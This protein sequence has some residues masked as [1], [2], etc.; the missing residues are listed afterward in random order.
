MLTLEKG[1]SVYSYAL[2]IPPIVRH[3]H[4]TLKRWD[5]CIGVILMALNL[6]MQIGLTFIV[7]QGVIVEGNKWRFTLVGMD[8]Q[9]QFAE[10]QVEKDLAQTNNLA[11]ISSGFDKFLGQ[12]ASLA[13]TSISVDGQTY[14]RDDY[15]SKK[16][17]ELIAKWEKELSKVKE[18]RAEV[19]S[20]L[21]PRK[22][23]SFTQ[24]GS[25]RHLD[26]WQMHNDP[27]DITADITLVDGAPLPKEAKTGSMF[28]AGRKTLCTMSN[29][30][31]NCL[32][33]SVRYADQW[34]NLDVNGD[35][36]WSLEEAQEDKN[37]FEKK[38]GAKAFLVFRAITVGLTDRTAVDPKLWVAPEVSAMKAIPKAYFDYWMGDA[39]LCSYADP[40]V[41][42]TLLSRDFFAEAMN[43]KNQG[44]DIQDID[45]AL[46]YCVWMLTVNGGCDQ[47]LPQ[48]YKLFRAQRAVQCGDGSL[49]NGGVWRNPHHDVD[50]VYI[51][52]VD[53]PGLEKHYKA[54]SPTYLFF[55]FLVLQLWFLALLNEMRELVK[56]GEFCHVFPE[57]GEDG[58]VEES[59]NDE[60]TEEYTITGLTKTDRNICVMCVAVRTLVV[61]Y[62]GAVGTVFLVMET[63]YMDLLMN[64]V[65]LAFILE[66]DEILFG[67]IVGASTCDELEACQDL[68]FETKLPTEGCAGWILQ[69]DFWGIIAFPIIAIIVMIL[70]QMLVTQ[71]VLDALDCGCNQ[72][73]PQ[74]HEAQL[75]NKA[76]WNNYWSSTLPTAM[77]QIAELKAKAGF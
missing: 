27:E 63:G 11:L 10:G 62:L 43:P 20:G 74:C 17:V 23:T 26:V 58:G 3:K 12:P 36:V 69:K 6:V 47:S 19:E 40:K 7:G 68:E 31:Y 51:T 25:E 52:A 73:G 77:S 71:P 41:C 29:A 24:M 66:I 65:A 35:G 22:P 75:Y 44:K 42:G 13:G 49:Y 57:A 64:A 38:F 34:H 28:T 32:P 45:G 21:R 5:I 33:P 8:V 48:I 60:G 15:I 37:G 61:I 55:L 14:D 18:D 70:Y 1:E 72:L 9:D 54:S 76:W 30:T 59:K 4:G 46:D 67:S 16:N 50:K 53:Y 39:A 2:F 56:L